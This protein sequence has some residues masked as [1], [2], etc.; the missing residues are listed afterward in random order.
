MK[1]LAKSIITTAMTVALAAGIAK[2]AH[3][4]DRSKIETT[5]STYEQALNNANTDKVMSLYT[6]DGVFMP[7][8]YLPNVGKTAVRAAYEGIFKTIKLDIEFTVDE[9]LQLSPG[10]AV[11]R[12]RSEGSI[13]IKAS[14]DK[15]PGNNQELFLLQKQNG[16]EW[17]I[18][19]YIFS[20]TNP[21]S[22]LNMAVS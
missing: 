21:P 13:I 10:W 5:L 20:T 6:D 22:Q 4:A 2:A 14:G 8:N 18:A 9:I 1:T 16:G 15:V 19:R 11:A 7:Q 3:S 17:K 12:T